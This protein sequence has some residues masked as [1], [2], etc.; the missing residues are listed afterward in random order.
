[1]YVGS[2]YAV[3]LITLH[4]HITYILKGNNLKHFHTLIQL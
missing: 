2:F 3:E 1:M 4:S